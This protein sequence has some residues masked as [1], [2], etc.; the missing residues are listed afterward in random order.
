MKF[1]FN[2]EWAE[3]LNGYPAEVRLEVYDAIIR[4]VQSGTLSELKPMAKMAFSFIKNEIDYNAKQY[5]EICKKRSEAG[6]K[7]MVVR[8]QKENL[9]NDNKTSKC[10]QKV[11]NLTDNEYEYDNNNK[12]KT[13]SN[14]IVKKKATKVA[15]L[16]ER[17]QSFALSLEPYL[18]KYSRDMLNDFYAYWTEENQS[19][20]KMRFELEKTWGLANRLATWAKRDNNFKTTSNGT[21]IKS[22][23]QIEREHREEQNQQFADHIRQKL[24]GAI[25]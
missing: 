10:Y 3:V 14:E 22:Y 20:T 4:Y 5:Q 16:A 23:Q 11:T 25:S 15:T 21:T 17:K 1:I 2:T 6:K 19:R 18:A 7:G 8:Y 13:I 24:A 12:E 9:T